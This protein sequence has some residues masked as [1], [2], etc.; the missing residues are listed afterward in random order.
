MI[1]EITEGLETYTAAWQ[2]WVGQRTNKPFFEGLLPTSVAWKVADLAAYNMAVSALQPLSDQ[3]HAAVV[4]ERWLATF[5]MRNPL[6][7]GVQLI[8]LMQLRPGSQDAIGLDHMDFYTPIADDELANRLRA[9]ANLK[10][11]LEASNKFCSWYSVWH[12]G[13]EAKL[14]TQTVLDVCIAEM[15]ETRNAV[16]GNQATRQTQ[17]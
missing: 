1:T 5:H 13:G 3:M 10:W 16:I 7:G 6:P 4:N 8:K 11:Q 9:E 12:K 14:R 2:E 17:A 15:K